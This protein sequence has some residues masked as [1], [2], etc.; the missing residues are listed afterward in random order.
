MDTI[1]AFLFQNN[2][3]LFGF[4]KGQGRSLSPSPPSCMPADY[5]RILN[6]PQ[7]SYNKIVTIVTVIMLE[8]FSA[9][10]EN[11]GALLVFYLFLTRV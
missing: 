4:Q 5:A 2:D 11:P 6:V 7:N 3:T 1:K 10:F 9:R 8:F